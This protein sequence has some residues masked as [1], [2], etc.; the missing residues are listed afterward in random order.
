MKHKILKTLQDLPPYEII[1]V[2]L[3][4]DNKQELNN[5]EAVENYLTFNLDAV[6]ILDS[7][8]PKY[9][10]KRAKSNIGI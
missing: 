5:P 9:I 10:I 1:Q 2:E 3:I 6:E 8:P 4:S 7:K